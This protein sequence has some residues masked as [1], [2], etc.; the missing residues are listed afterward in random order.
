M[1]EL[2]GYGLLWLSALSSAS[3]LPGSSEI[4]MGGLWYQ[5]YP[6]ILLWLCATSGNVAGSLINWWLGGQVARFS[7][8]RWFP[9]TP[10]QMQR[11]E[12]WMKKFGPFA[13]LLSWLPVVGDPLTLVA[14]VLR[15][16][17]AMFVA[18]VAIA[19]GAR[20][21]ILLLLADQLLRPLLSQG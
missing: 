19:K 1:N 5:G 2:M 16:P 15:M 3:L 11:A 14:G 18:L 17:I 8:K 6:A 10:E 9:A 4:V 12:V 20:Y 13:L 21:A 7:G